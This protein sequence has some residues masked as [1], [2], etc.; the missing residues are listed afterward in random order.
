MQQKILNW[1]CIFTAIIAAVSLYI[2][3][4]YGKERELIYINADLVE[5]NLELDYSAM[6][7]RQEEFII[8][9]I[10]SADANVMLSCTNGIQESKVH[11]INDYVNQLMIL[12][13]EDVDIFSQGLNP[14]SDTG[15]Y[16]QG[17]IAYYTE[18]GV[19]VVMHMNG[20]YEYSVTYKNNVAYFDFYAPSELY[21]KIV[22]IDP[23]EG[24]SKIGLSRGKVREKEVALEVAL[25]V[26]AK[27]E[28]LGYKVYYTRTSDCA[29]SEELRL[30]LMNE[31]MAD[32]AIRIG[33]G[34][35]TDISKHGMKALYNES[36]F[37]P[38][39]SS[40]ELANCILKNVVSKT[41]TKAI[42]LEQA[43]ENDVVVMGGTVPVTE[44]QIGMATNEMENEWL[45][46]E[47]YLNIVSEGIVEGIIESFEQL[48]GK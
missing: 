36:Y 7:L 17:A 37:I 20:L 40:V 3:V 6:S 26:Q 42:G 9:K 13:I 4:S 12:E 43:T 21:E 44:I 39:F 16:I 27:L 38:E 19:Y 1:A 29:V 24:G 45:Q 34:S 5:E 47:G 15:N 22:V 2:M 18:D 11:I 33:I 46:K 31:S 10:Q 8:Q 32:L 23:A 28:E 14:I 48:D 25:K 30:R 35:S 41:Q